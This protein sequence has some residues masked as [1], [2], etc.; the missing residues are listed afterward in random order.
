MSQLGAGSSIGSDISS[1]LI[2]RGLSFLG[3]LTAKAHSDAEKRIPLLFTAF[4]PLVK[5]ASFDPT[6]ETAP[7]YINA[8]RDLAQNGIRHVIF[9]HTHMPKRI[10]LPSGGWYLNS[11]TWAD[12]LQFPTEVLSGTREQSLAKI[13]QFTQ[14]MISGDF[15]EWTTFRPTYVR[16]DVGSDGKVAAAELV[17]YSESAAL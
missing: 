5:D 1:G 11:G 7:E 15:S 10:G 17:H 12:V 8:A 4:Q 6:V 3:L 16:L 2:E 14:L 9:G 13:S